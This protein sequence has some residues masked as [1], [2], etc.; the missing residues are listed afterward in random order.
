LRLDYYSIRAREFDFYIRFLKNFPKE[1]YPDNHLA[2]L[3][4]LPNVL[5]TTA[6]S[7]IESR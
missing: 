7:K 5:M 6:L 1:V 3:F 4:V 2:S